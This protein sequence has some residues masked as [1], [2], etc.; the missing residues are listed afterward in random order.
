[1]QFHFVLNVAVGGGFFAEGCT[2]KPFNKPWANSDPAQMR[3]F[4]EA[5]SQWL[6]GWQAAGEDSAMQIDYIRVYAPK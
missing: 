5:R 1:M 4:W 6:P 2:N 3:K